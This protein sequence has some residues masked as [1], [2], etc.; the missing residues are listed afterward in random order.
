MAEH[1][2]SEEVTDVIVGT[3]QKT[4]DK[5]GRDFASEPLDPGHS[6]VP[7]A[8][9]VESPVPEDRGVFQNVLF[10]TMA[11]EFGHG[12]QRGIFNNFVVEAVG[13]NPTELGFVQGI[14]EIPGLLTAPLAMLSR[15]FSENV[16]AGLCIITA[17]L[18]L[19][20]HIGV[21]GVPMLIV[22]TLVLSFGFHLFYP[23]QSSMVMKSCPL[24]ERATRMGQLNS[25]AA[26]SSLAA[27]AVVLLLSRVGGRANYNL[28]HLIA[29]V[30]ALVGGIMVLR[31][32]TGSAGR[33][34]TVIDFNVKYMSYYILTFL[35]GARRHVNATFGGYLLVE[36]Y[37][38]P[39]STMVILSAISS[40][41]A[42]ITRPF[43]GKV[44]DRWG[45]QKSLVFNYSLVAGLFCCYAFVK[46]PLLLYMIYVFDTGLVGFDVAITTHLG[47]IAP[48]EVLS[49]EYAM[50]STINHISGIAVPIIGGL[51]W[52]AVG[53]APVF[54]G[55]AAIALMSML[56]SRNLGQKEKIALS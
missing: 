41:I 54:L 10:A 19:L 21:N 5:K 42:I 38:T 50:G 27:F 7:A 18:G 1:R 17:A 37:K 45:E 34:A 48:K 56:Y 2:A 49:A 15:Y 33:P 9:D 44:I 35:G 24:E 32:K 30:S 16:Y 36:I 4:I 13:I 20:L 47:K 6:A 43:I 31:R 28:I 53:A 25:G 29:G 14:R 40:L 46:T 39:V 12:L 11:L 55:G 8:H 3:G 51:V 22:A 23:V 52:D 26:A